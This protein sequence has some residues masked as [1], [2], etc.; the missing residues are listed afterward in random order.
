MSPCKRYGALVSDDRGWIGG[1]QMDESRQRKPMSR[2]EMLRFAAGFAG[3]T[4]LGWI[5]AAFGGHQPT[6][7]GGAATSAA[8]GTATGGEAATSAVGGAATTAPGAAAS[9]GGQTTIS[10]LGWGSPLEKENVDKGLQLF[11]S[12]N[13][14]IKVDWLHT[15][16]DYPTK[17][18]T[19][20]AG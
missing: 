16:Q 3:A 2:R 10:M 17:L 18:K 4:V 15:P 1:L 8:G 14:D 11:Q 5:L 12:K 20:L 19:M 7:T 9:Q 6:T 13:P